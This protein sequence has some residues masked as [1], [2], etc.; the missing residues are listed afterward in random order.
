LT[1]TVFVGESKLSLTSKRAGKIGDAA[2]RGVF[3]PLL[4]PDLACETTP[5]HWVHPDEER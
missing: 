3:E 4:E 5:Y 1:T 2:D